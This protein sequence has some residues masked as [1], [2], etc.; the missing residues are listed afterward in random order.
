MKPATQIVHWPGKDTAACDDHLRQLIGLGAIL[1]CRID[2]TPCDETI[3][4]NCEN[5][6]KKLS[7]SDG[8]GESREQR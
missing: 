3:C 5:E 2:W 1:G 6:A 8:P 7:R 4:D